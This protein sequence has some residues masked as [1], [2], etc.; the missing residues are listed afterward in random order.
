M[1]GAFAAALTALHADPNFGTDAAWRRPP[2]DWVKLR[3]VLASPNDI[4][5]GLGGLGGLGARAGT[6]TA[7]V[8]SAD[9]T[10]LRGDELRIDGAVHRIEDAVRDPL[11]LSWRVTLSPV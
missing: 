7:T 11:G 6:V 2:A 8:L 4:V 5:P 1:S 10:P 9:A 3:V